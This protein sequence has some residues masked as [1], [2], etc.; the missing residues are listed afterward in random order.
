M[1]IPWSLGALAFALLPGHALALSIGVNFTDGSTN[2]SPGD[3]AGVPVFAQTH[4]NNT[5][6]SGS[7]LVDNSGAMTTASFTTTSPYPN[8]FA[9][10]IPG[11]A[12]GPDEKLN[13]AILYGSTGLTLQLSGISYA[14]YSLLVYVL[15]GNGLCPQTFSVGSTTFFGT[16]PSPSSPGY[17]DSNPNSPFI[18]TPAVGTSAATSTVGADYVLFSGLTGASQTLNVK[19]LDSSEVTAITGFQ[20]IASVPEPSTWALL[21]VGAIG[22]G[23]ALRRRSRA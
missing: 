8:I 3:S 7:A 9:D 14:A 12:K 5:G 1:K 20:I 11:Y 18:Y 22:L 15:P 13:A 10:F 2:L 19:C 23:L 21:G 6:T 4:Y 16:S 17:V